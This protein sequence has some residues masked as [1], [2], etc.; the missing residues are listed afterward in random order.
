MN[1]L[2]VGS[3]DFWPDIRERLKRPYLIIADAK[4]EGIAGQVFDPDRHAINP[5]AGM[6]YQRACDFVD[7]INA[8]F[9]AGESTLTRE[10]A[11]FELL[12]ALLKKPATLST[13]MPWSDDGPRKAAR[14]KLERMMMSP[15][16]EKVFSGSSF[17]RPDGD[18]IAVLDRKNLRDFDAF[19]LGHLLISKYETY[20]IVVDDFTFY[21]RPHLSYLWREERLICRVGALDD[22]PR[23]MRQA[24][25]LFP[26]KV[27][28][29]T[30]AKDAEELASYAGKRYDPLREDSDYNR[31]ISDL[32]A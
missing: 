2:L 32:L 27:G 4:P 15:V 9:P 26:D 11:A 16:L 6:N 14:Q 13:V 22:L 30:T 7:M 5:L 18:V 24:V 23:E 1:T 21:G 19:I 10:N 3:G 28:R 29:R 25:L 17:L 20:Q 8:A 12:E 31:F